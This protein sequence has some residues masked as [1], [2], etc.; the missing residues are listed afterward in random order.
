MVS[1]SQLP[2]LGKPQYSLK[3]QCRGA[4]V[5]LLVGLHQLALV[6]CIPSCVRNEKAGL[7]KPSHC[8]TE[9]IPNLGQLFLIL[10]YSEVP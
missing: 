10:R 8:G 3:S 2:Q 6:I 5:Q 1:P 9:F 4:V 7:L